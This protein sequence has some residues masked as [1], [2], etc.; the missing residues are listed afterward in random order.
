MSTIRLPFTE[1]VRAAMGLIAV[2]E[3]QPDTRI[4]V[5]GVLELRETTREM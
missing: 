3:I 5:E 1:A 4:E 2:D